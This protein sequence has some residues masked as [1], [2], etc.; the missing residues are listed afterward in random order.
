M[1]PGKNRFINSIKNL[2][3]DYFEIDDDENNI[4]NNNL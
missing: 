1:W 2:K 4:L 3:N